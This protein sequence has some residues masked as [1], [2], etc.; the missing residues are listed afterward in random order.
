MNLWKVFILMGQYTSLNKSKQIISVMLR[1]TRFNQVISP[2]PSLKKSILAR[3]NT[4]TYFSQYIYIYNIHGQV[5]PT[6]S[7]PLLIDLDCLKMCSFTER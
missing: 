6:S 7:N 5:D 3:H 4:G 2:S 1:K